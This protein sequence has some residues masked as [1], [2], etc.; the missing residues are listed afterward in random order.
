MDIIT[1]LI[2][3]QLLDLVCCKGVDADILDLIH[4]QALCIPVSCMYIG[5]FVFDEYSY[6]PCVRG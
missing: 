6:H 3:Q 2:L 5:T 4:H 1:I